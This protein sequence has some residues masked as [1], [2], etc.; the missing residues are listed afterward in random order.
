MVKSKTF[1]QDLLYRMRAVTIE[2]PSLRQR[3]DDIELLVAHYV[4]LFC[5]RYGVPQKGISHD[6]ME[7][8]LAYDW[9]G[10][11]RELVN[12]LEYA[13][14][15]A[16]AQ[17]MLF[18]VNLPVEL[19]VKVKESLIKGPQNGLPA[20]SQKIGDTNSMPPLKDSMEEMEKNYMVNLLQLTGNDIGKACEISGLSRTG[21]YSRLKKHQLSRTE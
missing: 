8:L 3:E 5:H 18:P 9:P 4:R 1:R 19:R 12:C 17:E 13:V 14:T 6:F 15:N 20:S 10:N 21:L 7:T 2:L 16:Q 11:V